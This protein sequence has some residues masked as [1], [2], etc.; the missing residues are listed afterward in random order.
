M[1][2]GTF[3]V[4]I[5]LEQEKRGKRDNLG[6]R[7]KTPLLRSLELTLFEI[8]GKGE[9]TLIC[10]YVVWRIERG[11]H[12]PLGFPTIVVF[13]SFLYGYEYS[14]ITMILDVRLSAHD[15]MISEFG[16]WIVCEVGF[17]IILVDVFDDDEH[18]DNFHDELMLMCK[19][20]ENYCMAYYI[21]TD[22]E[23]AV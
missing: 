16:M 22:V 18:K 2:A 3:I 19:L 7:N 11:L 21:L 5:I 20:H 17:S 14:M 10:V 6:F 12:H 1:R 15:I 8:Q 23:V 4:R 9:F 13:M